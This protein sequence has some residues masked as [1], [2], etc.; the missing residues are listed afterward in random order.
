MDTKSLLYGLIGFF[1]GGLLVS[2]VATVQSDSDNSMTMSQMTDS[3]KGKSGDEFD[4]AFLQEMISHHKGA[5][6]MAKLAEKQAKHDEIKKLSLDIIKTQNNEINQMQSWQE[7][8][9]Y[10]VNH[11][12]MNH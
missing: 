7:R 11:N 3:L 8:W 6:D 9:G 2:I 5:V 12:S 4:K 1:I 10:S